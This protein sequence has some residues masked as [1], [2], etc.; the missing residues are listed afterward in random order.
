MSL[1]KASLPASQAIIRQEPVV[2]APNGASAFR[3]LYRSMG[4]KGEPTAVSVLVVVPGGTS[5]EGGRPIVAWAH[6]TSGVVQRCAPSLARHK[7]DGIQ[8]LAKM[9]GRGY[10]VVAT[11]YPGLGT[12]GTHPYLVGVSEARAVIDSVRPRASCRMPA[13]AANTPH[14]AIRKAARPCSSPALS[15]KS[16]LRSWSLS[17]SPRLHPP[18]ISVR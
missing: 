8:G 4:L 16:T 5:P 1:A 12:G 14:G 7:F 6:P 15:Q 17:V 11:D 10:V 13:A 9:I 2:G 3:I 18:P